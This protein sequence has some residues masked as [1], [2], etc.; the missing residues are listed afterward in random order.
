MTLRLTANARVVLEHRYLRKNA[1]GRIIE[2]PDQLMMRVAF[3]VA[4][5]DGKY[6]TDDRLKKVRQSVRMPY[7]EICR[8]GEVS[9]W[10]VNLSQ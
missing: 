6:L 10:R 3:N 4:C 2:T 8:T 9:R 1:K 5:G 7:W